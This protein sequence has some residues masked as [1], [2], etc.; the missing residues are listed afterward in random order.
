MSYIRDIQLHCASH[1]LA[2]TATAPS[3]KPST[4]ATATP[5]RSLSSASL[6]YTGS[7]RVLKHVDA[8][9][10]LPLPAPETHTHPTCCEIDGATAGHTHWPVYQDCAQGCV[11][12]MCVEHGGEGVC[13]TRQQLHCE[14]MLL[15]AVSH[16]VCKAAR[17][18]PRRARA[19]VQQL[20]ALRWLHRLDDPP[21]P[22]HHRRPLV[23]TPTPH[24]QWNR[25]FAV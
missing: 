18:H 15:P 9:G 24:P 6:P 13:R 20:R 21:E 12:N 25:H 4:P 3:S 7:L 11:H 2:Y 14:A 17:W 22:H 23:A 16:Q 5:S 19:E 1:R 8:V 10:S